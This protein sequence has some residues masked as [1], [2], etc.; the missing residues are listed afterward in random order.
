MLIRSI[1]LKSLRKG[2]LL[3]VI[4]TAL[5]SSQPGLASS[6]QMVSVSSPGDI[7]WRSG[8]YINGV[9]D[10]ARAVAVDGSRIYVGGN[11]TVAGDTAA[12]HVAMWDGAA[13]HALG[14]GLNGIVYALAVDG[15]G[16]LYA[17]G[18]FTLA[19]GKAASN[20]ARWD[21][22]VWESLGSGPN[23]DV[24]A[25][26]VLSTDVYAGGYFNMA[27]NVQAHGI[28]R[29][30]G[31]KWQPLGSGMFDRDAKSGWVNA[32]TIDRYGF[33][34]AGG[35][36]TIAEGGPA[37][38][39]ARWDGKQWSALGG[40]IGVRFQGANVFALATDDRGNL[41]VGGWFDSA[42]GVSVS[43]L[44][45][46]NG[47]SWSGVGEEAGGAFAGGVRTILADG[48]NVYVGGTLTAT[49]KNDPS[50]IEKWNGTTW[51][52]LSGDVS[53]YP[54]NLAMDRNG[55]LFV[56]G[57][58]NSIGGISANNVA[59][60]DGLGWSGLGNDHS[61]N[62]KV[63]AMVSDDHGGAYLGG[64]FLAAG[65]MT[66]NSIAHWDGTDWKGLED[67]LTGAINGGAVLD[68]ALD[69]QGNLYAGGGFVQAGGKAANH[70]ARWNGSSWEALGDGVNGY[71]YTLVF[72]GGGNLFVGGGFD[73]AGGVAANNVA[74]WTG[75]QW[76]ALDIGTN[77][78]VHSL[79]IDDDNRL[80]AGGDFTTAGEVQA[81][82]VARWNGSAWES[83]SDQSFGR[84]PW[85][86][87][88][89]LFSQG[90]LYFIAG[91]VWVRRDGKFQLLGD[92]ISFSDFSHSLYAV[93]MALD[94]Q[95]NLVVGGYFD[96]AGSTP[97]NCIARWNGTNWENLGSGMDNLVSALAVASD[98]RL[99][100]G[101]G[102]SQAGG[103][104]S[105]YFAQWDEP[106]FQWLPMINK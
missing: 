6:Q 25:L 15:R 7:G 59:K 64:D 70:V 45:R 49:G 16:H 90:T 69:K 83:L 63:Y 30:D 33:L 8:F 75:T 43:N 71:V 54:N 28:A 23:G 46:W 29:W 103:K 57:S 13:W 72:D 12:N 99:F 73:H 105:S 95:G 100:A 93:T 34:Y 5:I 26:A 106:Y 89:L 4:V 39:M 60:W 47:E 20:I 84:A 42:G 32:L 41:Y 82:G 80:I 91:N 50:G 74:K 104:V 67:G 35:I 2:S 51:E 40:S 37:N 102:F 24:F 87:K 88:R 17:G 14:S 52:E 66:V 22:Q 56:V 36:F 55:N 1:I 85:I 3:F 27:G 92:G 53:A 78:T 21:G 68:L 18:S 98:G 44:A 38:Y 31:E 76:E 61:V 96:R 97:A 48:G 58:F 79:V 10:S 65:G 62:G 94:G 9:N 81:G 101:G 77:D 11:F 86:P 19:G